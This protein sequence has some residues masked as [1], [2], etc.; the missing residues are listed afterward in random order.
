MRNAFTVKFCS[1]FLFL[2]FIFF[3]ML[4]NY[5][6]IS[7]LFNDSETFRFE[8]GKFSFTIDNLLLKL[9]NLGIKNNMFRRFRGFLSQRICKVRHRSG[10]SKY[11]VLKIGSPQGSVHSC[12]LLN[13]YIN[14]LIHLLKSVA[15]VKCLLYADD[16]VMWTESQKKQ[17]AQQIKHILNLA[18]ESLKL[19]CDKNN[20]KVNV[21][22]IVAVSFS[23][24]HQ[25][26]RIDLSYRGHAVSEVDNF[27]YFSD[28]RPKTFLEN[29]CR[30]HG[31]S[32]FT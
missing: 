31:R 6:H 10:F 14:K 22:K 23:L 1:H 13:I 32:C 5:L 11:G 9:A 3:F 25:P 2:F 15:G 28:L 19:W 7:Y 27:T 21:C 4:N 20:M 12:T 26:L 16:F 8:H 18:L 17:A 29:S 24:T 30:K